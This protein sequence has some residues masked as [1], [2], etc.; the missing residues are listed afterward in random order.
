MWHFKGLEGK[1]NEQAS[2]KLSA[3]P[4]NTAAPGQDDASQS[5]VIFPDSFFSFTR[6]IYFI[7]LFLKRN[8]N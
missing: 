4:V 7:N 6:S 1:E 8:K 2:G 3:G 5:F